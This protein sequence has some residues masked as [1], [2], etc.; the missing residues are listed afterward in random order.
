MDEQRSLLDAIFERLEAGLPV[1][2]YVLPD[3]REE[4]RRVPLHGA[5]RYQNWGCRCDECRAGNAAHLRK[6][7]RQRRLG[8][9]ST[10]GSEDER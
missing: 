3:P 8:H 2:V 5:S 9:T 10:S 1:T 4:Y 6:W 7:K